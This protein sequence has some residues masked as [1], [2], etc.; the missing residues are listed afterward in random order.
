MQYFDWCPAFVAVA[1]L[2][3]TTGSTAAQNVA[4]ELPLESRVRA[5]TVPVPEVWQ[6]GQLVGWSPDTLQLQIEGGWTRMIP[7]SDLTRLQISRGEKTDAVKGALTGGVLGLA[8]GTILSL[9]AYGILTETGDGIRF[10]SMV[11]LTATTTAVGAGIGTIIGGLN[12]SDRWEDVPLLE[13]DATPRS[14]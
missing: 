7:M 1:A 2:F 13:P 12:R 4:E 10:S 9:L 14:R 11:T 6:T 8:A 3:V 5:L